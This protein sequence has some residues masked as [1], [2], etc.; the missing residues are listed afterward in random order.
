MITVDQRSVPV[1][2]R[3]GM[4][5]TLMLR[6]GGGSP[7]GSPACGEP[8]REDAKTEGGLTP[9][10]KVSELLKIHPGKGP[11]T[12]LRGVSQ[13]PTRQVGPTTRRGLC[14][15]WKRCLTYI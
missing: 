5:L 11:G 12:H 7:P 13:A 1:G 8:A 3:R 4:S 9:T 10:R 15:D 6:S 14:L 2:A